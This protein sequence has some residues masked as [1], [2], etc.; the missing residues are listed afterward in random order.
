MGQQVQESLPNQR[1]DESAKYANVNRRVSAQTMSGRKLN[2]DHAGLLTFACFRADRPRQAQRNEGRLRR[3]RRGTFSI[4][5]FASPPKQQTRCDAMAPRNC[6]NRCRRV[7][8]LY[9]NRLLLLARP[10]APSAG[11]NDVRGA[12]HRSRHGA[13]IGSI[14]VMYL[15]SSYIRTRRPSPSGY[16]ETVVA[17]LFA[18][19]RIACFCSRVHP[20]RVPAITMCVGLNIGPDMVPT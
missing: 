7:I 1:F 19:I 6:R 11:N 15:A 4:K 3:Q 2:L 13:D 18:S 8:R 16:A 17:G 20:R 5:R 10:P 14:G 9:Q 12:R